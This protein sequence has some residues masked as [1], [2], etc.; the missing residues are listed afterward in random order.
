VKRAALIGLISM[1]LCGTPTAAHPLAVEGGV[2]IAQVRLVDS[3]TQLVLKNVGQLGWAIRDL[4][5]VRDQV[6]FTD[7]G[8][9]RAS[10]DGT[11][12]RRVRSGTGGIAAAVWSPN[13]QEVAVVTSDGLVVVDV[14]SGRR[15]TIATNAAYPS[16]SADSRR[17]AYVGHW[18]E[19]SGT[20][21]VTTAAVDGSR[22]RELTPR[23]HS[24]DPAWSE[25]GR[26]IAYVRQGIGSPPRIRVVRRDGS[27]QKT[28]GIGLAPVWST[29]SEE[30]AFLGFAGTAFRS[31]R[32]LRI[33]SLGSHTSRRIGPARPNAV[34]AWSPDGRS[35]AYSRATPR[36][37]QVY[38]AQLST[39]SS[40]RLTND[41]N[42]VIHGLFWTPNARKILYLREPPSNGV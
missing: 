3:K 13:G 22:V 15:S 11:G 5:P 21:T 2:D 35:I 39:G 29:R 6:L 30:L 42:V 37:E 23:E 25:D 7:G 33:V 38:V 31:S 10:L 34:P 36:G 19:N 9:F 41:R 4:S 26:W 8:L 40:R 24:S 1:A 14:K 17:L 27:G 12:V 20:G 28:L 16:W 18:D 32:T